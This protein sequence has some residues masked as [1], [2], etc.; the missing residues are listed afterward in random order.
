VRFRSGL[1]VAIILASTY[2][3]CTNKG[4]KGI[5]QGEIHYSIEYSGKIGMPK[6]IMPRNLIVSFKNDK[7]LFDISA[8]IG[9]SGI[10]NLSNPEKGIFDTY[11]SLLSWKYSYSAKPGESHP[12]FEA[13]EG[14]EIKKSSKTTV[15]CGFNCKYAEVTLPGDRSKKYDIWY[16]NDIKVENP[17]AATP[18][19]DIDGVLMDFFF[20]M[21]SAE[22]HFNAETVYKKDIPDKIFE[23]RDKYM[24]VSRE[25][26]DK[27][28]NK[29]VSL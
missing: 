25:E 3:S 28:I 22:M 20:M 6:E 4:G 5:S 11:I 15:I 13:M 21:G 7:I 10:M 26:I 23:R 12:G 1:F 16:T 27:F 18:Y 9:N 8:P 17:N 29:M 2:Y 24:R 14:M 19:R